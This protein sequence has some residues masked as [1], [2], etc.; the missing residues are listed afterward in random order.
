VKLIDALLD[1][2]SPPE[3]KLPVLFARSNLGD[4][5]LV[6]TQVRQALAAAGVAVKEVRQ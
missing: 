5:L 3:V 2:S 4:R 1:R 6:E